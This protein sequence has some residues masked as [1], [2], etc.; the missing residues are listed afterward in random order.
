MRSIP[1]SLRLRVQSSCSFSTTDLMSLYAWLIDHGFFPASI[2]EPRTET[3]RLYNDRGA[4]V[5]LF[6]TGSV[7]VQGKDQPR[8]L[9]LLGQLVVAEEQA[10]QEVLPW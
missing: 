9:A 10:A 4:L 6:A 1:N 5:V 8:T 7:L 3:A 2:R